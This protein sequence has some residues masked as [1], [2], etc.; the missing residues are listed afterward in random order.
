MCPFCNMG[1]GHVKRQYN[2]THLSAYSADS[3]IDVNNTQETRIPNPQQVINKSEWDE[4]TAFN[5][6]I[7]EDHVDILKRLNSSEYTCGFCE[8]GSVRGEPSCAAR[9]LDAKSMVDHLRRHHAAGPRRLPYYSHF[10][11]PIQMRSYLPVIREAAQVA[12][13][14]QV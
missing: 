9:F 6:H 2:R 13:R 14:M 12:Q 4:A 10:C 3:A 1:N 5:A 8:C 11:D 7:L